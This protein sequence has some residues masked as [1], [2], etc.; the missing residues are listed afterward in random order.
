MAATSL[1]ANAIA[2]S[3]AQ[4]SVKTAYQMSFW[5]LPLLAYSH[6]IYLHSEASQISVDSSKPVFCSIASQ[7]ADDSLFFFHIQNTLQPATVS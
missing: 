7:K 3:Y 6:V 4:A 1:V 5:Q 2:L